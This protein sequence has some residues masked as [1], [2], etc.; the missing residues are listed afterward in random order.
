MGFR[1]YH[2]QR[3]LLLPTWASGITTFSL[4]YYYPHGLQVSPP[5]AIQPNKGSVYPSILYSWGSVFVQ[6]WD[7]VFFV[8]EKPMAILFVAELYRFTRN[9]WLSC[10][11]F[12]LVP[13]MFNINFKFPL[14]AWQQVS[15]FCFFVLVLIALFFV[16]FIFLLTPPLYGTL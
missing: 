16:T 8:A 3:Y 6:L 11:V 13:V 10:S 4:T 1:Y 12:V 15:T 2:L 7:S 5:S 9:F 14:C